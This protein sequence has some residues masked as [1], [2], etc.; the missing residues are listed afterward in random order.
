MFKQVSKRGGG[1]KVKNCLKWMSE[2]WSQIEG[3][4]REM[5]M[6]VVVDDHTGGKLNLFHQFSQLE[7]TKYLACFDTKHQDMF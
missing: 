7:L 6:G 2:M 4:K 1:E 3:N 5:G